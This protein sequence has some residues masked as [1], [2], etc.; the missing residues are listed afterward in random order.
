MSDKQTFKICITGGPCAGKTTAM[1]R[2]I[3]TFS[4]EFNV[5]TVPEMATM[6]FSSGVTILPEN[7]T[8]EMHK[9]FTTSICQMQIHLENYFETIAKTQ[10]KKTLI[11]TDRGVCDNFVYCSTENK[12]KILEDEK[13]SMD[14][15]SNGR[16]DMVIHM[17]TAANGAEEHY[18][19]DNNSARWES[20]QQAIENDIKGQKEWMHHHNFV[21]IDNSCKGFEAKIQRV[22]KSV[23]NISGAK[24]QHKYVKKFLLPIDFSF[25]S[26]PAEIKCDNFSETRHN[27]I[28]NREDMNHLIMKRTYPNQSFPVF[29]YIARNIKDSYEQR[30]ET[31]R[32]ISEKFYQDYLNQVD[33][34]HVTIHKQVRQFSLKQNKEVNIYQIEKIT[35]LDSEYCIL[36][37]IRDFEPSQEEKAVPHFVR[38]IEEITE[39][40]AYFS[41]NFSKLKSGR[42]IIKNEEAV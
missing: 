3:E 8:P 32:I 28:S 33:P 21:L 35:M 15:V 40:P 11:I 19:L 6:T 36:K 5:Y 29:F 13:W 17:V 39:N 37:I 1:S 41:S 7:F 38:V 24:T 20:R 27:L 34:N 9:V 23:A 4:P 14:Y 12:H 18:T 42:L 25:D 2:L 10:R 16:Y 22:L 26:I 31:H 30:I